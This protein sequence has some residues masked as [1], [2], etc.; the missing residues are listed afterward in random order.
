MIAAAMTSWEN[1]FI[2]S[3]RRLEGHPSGAEARDLMPCLSA[4]LKSCPFQ[5]VEP[6]QERLSEDQTDI[7]ILLP[8]TV[9]EE[10][11]ERALSKVMATPSSSLGGACFQP[12]VFAMVRRSWAALPMR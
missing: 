7:T 4:R 2:E 1:S 5:A 3:G 9:A 12:L 10:W 8:Q 6:F 11:R